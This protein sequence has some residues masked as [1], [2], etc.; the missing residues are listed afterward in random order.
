MGWLVVRIVLSVIFVQVG[1][2]FVRYSVSADPLYFEVFTMRMILF[3]LMA[4]ER[5]ENIGLV[6]LLHENARLWV[7]S[8][9]MVLALV[10]TFV[11]PPVVLMSG[12][13]V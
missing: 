3:W 4:R 8:V 6:P 10:G 11:C 13:E 1:Q 5:L 2:S 12:M 9:G 7:L